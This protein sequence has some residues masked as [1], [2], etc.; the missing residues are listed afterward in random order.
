MQCL[1]IF[2]GILSA[3]AM[4]PNIYFNFYSKVQSINY[5][6]V[7][8]LL[9]IYENL[10]VPLE[11][12]KHF[13]ILLNFKITKDY[14]IIYDESI[15]FLT[16][17]SSKNKIIQKSL[18]K[19]VGDPDPIYN[20]TTADGTLNFQYIL[21]LN[22]ADI[23]ESILKCKIKKKEIFGQFYVIKSFKYNENLKVYG[24]VITSR[25][26]AYFTIFDEKK[27]L[28]CDYENEFR[29]FIVVSGFILILGLLILVEIIKFVIL[30]ILKKNSTR[31]QIFHRNQ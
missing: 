14:H 7:S 13:N 24:E 12:N 6:K 8:Y 19:T 10:S 16:N 31:I 17:K 11:I 21:F 30:K 23:I 9:Y 22:I 18:L 28:V 3:E 26:D 5:T 25:F 1:I 29:F 27:N 15:N 20:R 4:N 2:F